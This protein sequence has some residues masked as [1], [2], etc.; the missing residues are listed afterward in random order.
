MTSKSVSLYP[1]SLQGSHGR[2]KVP[3]GEGELPG[4]RLRQQEAQEEVPVLRHCVYFFKWGERF[5]VV[6]Q[7][8]EREREME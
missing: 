1:R 6:S 7:R 4:K 3:R 2:S 5:A 8:A